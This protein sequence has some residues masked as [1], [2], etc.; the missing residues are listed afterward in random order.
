[1]AE[2]MKPKYYSLKNELLK[3]SVIEV[4]TAARSNPVRIGSNSG[5]AWWKAKTLIKLYLLVPML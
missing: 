3:E 1:M 4:V 2:A 5:G